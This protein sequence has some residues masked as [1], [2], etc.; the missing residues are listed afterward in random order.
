MMIDGL[1]SVVM[2]AYNAA[3]TIEKS[4]ETV[5]KQTYQSW[6]LIIVEDCSKD[7]TLQLLEQYK[8]NPKIK[9]IANK[10][11]SGAAVTRNNALEAAQG[12]YVAFLDS[13]DL[14]EP[15]K[16]EKQIAFLTEKKVGF[17]FT[18][19]SC[20]DENGTD[21]GREI[22]VPP[23][24]SDKQL[25]GN[26]IIGCSTVLIDR[27][28]IQDFR[29]VVNNKREDTFAWYLILKSGFIAYGM[30]EMLMKYRVASSSSSSNKYKMAKEYYRGLKE[31]AKLNLFQRVWYF[32]SY[33][34]HALKKRA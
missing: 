2:P 11:N 6:E 3:K 33:A 14:W 34:F 16:L 4:I 30:D 9:V 19:Y 21:M 8:D 5:L 10:A 22:H 18:S 24:V 32:G 12:Q 7:Q 15:E 17:S 20:I 31:I 26:T 28:I 13:D 23:T 29:F 27:S 25:L 1:V